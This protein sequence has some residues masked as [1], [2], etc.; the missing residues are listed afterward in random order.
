MH[1]KV[2]VHIWLRGKKKKEK[3]FPVCVC[4]DIRDILKACVF[5]PACGRLHMETKSLFVWMCVLVVRMVGSEGGLLNVCVC[6]C[7]SSLFHVIA[8]LSS[9]AGGFVSLFYMHA[10]ATVIVLHRPSSDC[11]EGLQSRSRLP[12]LLN[13]TKEED[14][15]PHIWP[16]PPLTDTSIWAQVSGC[17]RD[18]EG[19]KNIFSGIDS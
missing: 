7:E 18:L 11:G 19:F 15:V 4:S 14:N 6:L 13:H 10:M 2:R 5:M 1:V 3:K 8:S 17:L 16:F 9:Q 12:S